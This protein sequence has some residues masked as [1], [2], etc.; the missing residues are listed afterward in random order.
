MN[1][2]G[3]NLRFAPLL[4][5]LAGLASSGVAVDGRIICRLIDPAEAETVALNYGIEL[6]D[7]TD[8][9][10]FVLY[11]AASEE[12]ADLVQLAM[13]G[14]PRIAWAEDD[15]FVESPETASGMGSVTNVIGDRNA[16]YA[17]N[18]NWLS[19]IRWR[20]IASRTATRPVR[21]A[22]LDTGLSPQVPRLWNRV[23]AAQNML[24][25]GL[26]PHD[27]PGNLNTNG[28]GTID[29][30]LGHGTMVAGLVD[31]LAPNVDLVIARVADSDGVAN[32]WTIIKGLAFAATQGAEIANLSMGSI[33]RIAALSD[34]LDWT[35][36]QNL[37]VICPAGNLGLDEVLYPAGYR[38]VMCVTGV[39]PDDT[40]APFSNWGSD[41]DLAAPATGIESTWIDG[42]AAVWSGTSFAAP[43]VAAAAADALRRTAPRTA[44]NLHDLLSAAGDSIDAQNP[45]Y[46]G[47]LGVRLNVAMVE[48]RL[49]KGTR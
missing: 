6:R 19:Q 14:D 42:R 3:R 37:L 47:K 20:P 40:K 26:P 10:P 31:L 29:D 28:N 41:A 44:E 38:S 23:V 12:A 7:R 27:L 48:S 25:D 21:L 49:R 33:D 36:E 34:V 39:L 13:L 17:R 32:A 46:R 30:G 8:P 9:A 2:L 5:L 11:R 43:M 16:L 35:D 45:D 4:A 24:P 15:G 18:A 22:I 1:R